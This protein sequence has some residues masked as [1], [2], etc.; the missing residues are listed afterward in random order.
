MQRTNFQDIQEEISSG[1][2]LLLYLSMPHCS[3]CHAIKPRIEEL[4]K[5]QSF[6]LFHLDVYQYPEAAGTFQI[7]TA[8][9]VLVFF[10]GKE[11]HRQGRFIDFYKLEKLIKNYQLMD[12]SI[13]YDKLFQTKNIPHQ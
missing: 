8:P 1:K 2:L 4:F 3:V 9:V 7:F 5:E 6:P 11:V 10:E 12:L 13:D